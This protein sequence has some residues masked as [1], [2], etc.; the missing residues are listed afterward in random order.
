[1]E[2]SYYYKDRQV[3]AG[4]TYYYKLMDVGK[5]GS[6]TLRG[7]VQAQVLLPVEFSLDQNYPNPFNPTTTIRFSLKESGVVSLIIYNLQ[8]QKIRTLVDQ[9]MNSGAHQV[10]WDS[11]DEAGQAAASGVY[12]YILRGNGYQYTRRM[13]LIR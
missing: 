13:N 5:D 1:M 10:V 7:P 6:S 11:R 2:H 4:R 9:E 12:L 8:G 3:L